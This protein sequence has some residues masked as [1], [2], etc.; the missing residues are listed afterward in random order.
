MKSSILAKLLDRID[1]V[2]PNELQSYLQQLAREKGFLEVIFN[3][4]QEGILVIDAGGKIIY[5]NPSIQRM[6][7][8]PDN[9]IGR[10]IGEF[11]RELD[12]KKILRERRVVSRDLEVYYPD[13]RFLNFYLVPLEGDAKEFLG[14]AVIFHDITATRE[15]TREVIES[16]K[17]NALTLLAAGVAHELGNPLNSLHIHLQLLERDLKKMEGPRA[18]RLVDSVHVAQSE[19]SRLDHIITQF[20]RAVR[21]GQPERKPSQINEII[22]ESLDFLKPEIQDRDILVETELAGDL[23]LV[24]VDAG[25]MKQAIYNLVKNSIHAMSVG[26][27]LR[28]RTERNDTH[29]LI[30]FTDNGCGIAAE[31][32]SRIFE[33]YFTTKGNGSGLGLFIVRRI[34]R[35]HGGDLILESASGR[36][37]TA[38][39][40]LPLAERRVRMLPPSSESSATTGNEGKK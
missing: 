33:P 17:V 36:G 11:L 19:I 20:L 18:S 25:Q 32:V 2:G 38:R 29:L 31:N 14:F 37:T 23:P 40:A 35:E 8:L 27:I 7:G 10:G 15:R 28:V 1:Q 21:P 4:L 6:I 5:I 34:V 13:P 30:S 24:P 26:G 22:R 12:W 16:E 9:A 39:I 3:T